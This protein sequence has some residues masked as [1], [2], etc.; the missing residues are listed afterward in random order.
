[1]IFKDS[2]LKVLSTRVK[3]RIVRHFLSGPP[4][5]SEREA[6]KELK[7]SHM[8]VNRAVN[9]LQSINFLRSS[10]A[11]NVKLWEVNESSFSY[12]IIKNILSDFPEAE[13]PLLSL[14]KT[15][16]KGLKGYKINKAVL[17]G[18][19][20]GANERPG[21]DLDLLVVMG[22]EREKEKLKGA[23]EKL[24]I[25]CLE[26]YGNPLSPYLL[27]LK[28]YEERSSLPVIKEMK[29]GIMLIGKDEFILKEESAKMARRAIASMQKNGAK[30]LSEEDIEKEI[31]AA[32][33]SIKKR[34]KK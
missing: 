23:V 13:N 26:L 16:L 11:G 34:G 32:R 8:S 18:S 9:E 4:K 7:V 5:M 3:T 14:K 25:E 15:I 31:K 1:M 19:V 28:E 21:S 33:K 27:T 29:S 24:E 22:S 2:V 12:K 10:R 17:F 30:G 20:A 6:A